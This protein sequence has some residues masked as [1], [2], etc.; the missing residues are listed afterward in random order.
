M[1]IRSTLERQL[2]AALLSLLVGMLIVTGSVLAAFDAA[3]ASGRAV[4]HTRDVIDSV[5][6]LQILERQWLLARTNEN[7][8][9]FNQRWATA[10][11][12]VQDNPAQ[13]NRLQQWRDQ[14]FLSAPTGALPTQLQANL[15]LAQALIATEE[16]LLADRQR[17]AQ[18]RIQ[19][20]RWIMLISLPM[21]A[22][23]GFLFTLRLIHRVRHFTGPLLSA[24]ERVQSGDLEVRL[25]VT[26]HDEFSVI[27]RHFNSMTETLATTQR[28]QETLRRTLEFRVETLVAA[29]TAELQ[30]LSRL[31]TFIQASSTQQEA[32]IVI[33]EI[34]PT[35]FPQGGSVALLAESRNLLE[36]Y[37]H[38]GPAPTAPPWLPSECWASRLGGIHLAAP[39]GGVPRCPHDLT[40]GL[41]QAPGF[42]HGVSQAAAPQGPPCCSWRNAC[43]RIRPWQ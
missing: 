29:T 5:R 17:E 16:T 7:R 1:P 18:R 31:G 26:G 4:T 19:L 2:L 27:S 3:Q 9:A 30:H 40:T 20:A 32:A 28:S 35:L 13:Q 12:D 42:I 22:V 41:T 23:I 14:L 36:P 37:V 39:Q 38:W 11:A 25:P 33:A 21:I 15:S 34:A 6:T 10:F 24:T 43:S 8:E